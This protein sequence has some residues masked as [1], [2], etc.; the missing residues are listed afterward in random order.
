MGFNALMR[1]EKKT[2][3]DNLTDLFPANLELKT[4]QI[5]ERAVSLGVLQAEQSVLQGE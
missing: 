2:K 5:S 4:N 1:Q 3:I